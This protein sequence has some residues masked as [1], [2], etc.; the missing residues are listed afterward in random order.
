MA[1]ITDLEWKPHMGGGMAKVKFKN[2]YGASVLRG[3]RGNR[4]HTTGKTFEIAVEDNNGLNY[5]TPITDGVLKYQSEDDVNQALADIEA[6]PDHPD[7]G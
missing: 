5:N 4:F 1:T 7:Q 2:G 3:G 6:L